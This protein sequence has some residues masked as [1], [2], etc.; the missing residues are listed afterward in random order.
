MYLR[1]LIVGTALTGCAEHKL[2]P[3]PHAELR[4]A[5][6]LDAE[7]ALGVFVHALAPPDS[8][9]QHLTRLHVDG[10]IGWSRPLE[11]CGDLHSHLRLDL[12]GG[13]AV[14]QCPGGAFLVR[15]SDGVLTPWTGPDTL[16]YLLSR[17]GDARQIFG[18]FHGDS[19]SSEVELVALDAQDPSTRQ[20]VYRLWA[21]DLSRPLLWRADPRHLLVPEQGIGWRVLR[22]EDGVE[23][24]RFNA[25]DDGICA[26]GGRWWASRGDRLVSLDL[27]G[28]SPQE[29]EAP[30]DF[31]PAAFRWQWSVNGC[32]SRGADTILWAETPRGSVVVGLDAS[33]GRARWSIP[34][35]WSLDHSEAGVSPDPERLGATALLRL[36]SPCAIDL[37][38][39]ELRWCADSDTE[40]VTWGE[41]TL[42]VKRDADRHYLARVD[43]AGELTHALEIRGLRPDAALQPRGRRLW[44]AGR[45]FGDWNDLPSATLD[46]ET[47]TGVGRASPTITWTDARAEIRER[48]GIGPRPAPPLDLPPESELHDP[49]ESYFKAGGAAGGAPPADGAADPAALLRAA[50]EGIVDPE[51]VRIVAWRTEQWSSRNTRLLAF[52]EVPT[53]G[54]E[55]G[56]IVLKLLAVD[57]EPTR[58]G[59]VWVFFAHRPSNHEIFA[60]LHSPGLMGGAHHGS[61]LQWTDGLIDEAAWLALTGAPRSERW[62]RP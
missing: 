19:L 12:F 18:V 43:P 15:V 52:A 46:L 9:V 60:L 6:A 55:P 27:S 7:H 40:R 10:S 61:E 32:A 17:G 20:W 29:I 41:E 39:G 36:S 4:S 37:E 59:Q 13:S 48:L 22:R 33:T 30:A 45:E 49:L 14:V 31:I 11:R 23:A 21:P 56:W 3:F 47:F 8:A 16:P 25:D 50:T 57:G 5:L 1:L 38:R 24:A 42:L 54:G 35:P 2:R 44:L 58:D 53:A 28:S 51:K 62:W 34:T 26:A